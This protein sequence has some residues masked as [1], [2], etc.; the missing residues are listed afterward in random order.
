MTFIVL[1]SSLLFS[2]TTVFYLSP[3]VRLVCS[4]SCCRAPHFSQ[5]PSWSRPPACL[6]LHTTTNHAEWVAS[7]VLPSGPVWRFLWHVH[8]GGEL[9]AHGGYAKWDRGTPLR[10]RHYPAIGS[11]WG[12]HMPHHTGAC[13]LGEPVSGDEWWLIVLLVCTS[14]NTKKFGHLFIC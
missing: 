8:P 14:L 4:P 6:S 11:A 7:T 2:L 13:F 1:C 12:L 3:H 9:L 10:Q 5:P